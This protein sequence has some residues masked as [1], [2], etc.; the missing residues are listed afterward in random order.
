MEAFP[1][2]MR[3]LLAAV[4]IAALVYGALCLAIYLFQ[5]RMVYF[6]VRE[7]AATPGDFG[8]AYETVSLRASDGVQIEAWFIPAAEP[9][10]VVLYCHGN[11]GNISHRLD[12]LR[13]LHLE[14]LS[15]VIFDYRGYGHSEG[16]PSEQGTYLD[17]EIAWQHLVAGRGVEPSRIIIWGE[18][19]G[20][21]IA[22]WLASRHPSGGLVLQS[23]FT[24][25]PDVAAERYPFFPVRLLT[26]FRYNT[27]Q[28]LERVRQPVLVIHSRQDEMIAFRH[29]QNLFAIAHV[30]KMFLEISGSHNYGLITS[31][32]VVQ[33][34]LRS[35]LDAHLK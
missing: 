15:V 19:L 27:A 28:N 1:I 14:R 18:S 3:T 24:S 31:S 35:F 17:A 25:V 34:G 30:P 32:D 12:V 7:M 23:T 11:G 22:S 4:R 6:P 9:R 26:R 20:G 13:L 5:S 29:G 33:K 16:S 10:G 8:L 21:A 2:M